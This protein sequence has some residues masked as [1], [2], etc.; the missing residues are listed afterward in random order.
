MKTIS[1]IRKTATVLDRKALKSL[2]GGAGCAAGETKYTCSISI[3]G[4]S[5]YSGTVCAKSGW[6]ARNKVRTAMANQ[7]V[8]EYESSCG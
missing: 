1:E 7:F 4:G 6:D 3:G 2:L 8:E 5:S